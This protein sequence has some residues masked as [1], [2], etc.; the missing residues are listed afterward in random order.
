MGDETLH[1]YVSS[2][3][4]DLQAERAAVLEVTNRLLGLRFLGMEFF[5]SRDETTARTPVR[6]Q[7]SIRPASLCFQMRSLRHVLDIE[8]GH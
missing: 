4:I 7:Y 8:C 6:R 2:T 1:V 3:W 5:G